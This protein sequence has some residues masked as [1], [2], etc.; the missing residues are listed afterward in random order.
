[1]LLDLDQLS[2]EA[3]YISAD[4]LHAPRL[5]LPP[6]TSTLPLTSA[7]AAAC[8]RA[9]C[10]QAAV[11]HRFS[12]V[13][14][15][16]VDF[17]MCCASSYPPTTNTRPPCNVAAVGDVL[18]WSKD[19]VARQTLFS[20]SYTLPDDAAGC[21]CADLPPGW[22]Q[23]VTTNPVQKLNRHLSNHSHAFSLRSWVW[24]QQIAMV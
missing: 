9:F 22:P 18:L 17:K 6:D 20:G 16:S 3:S 24:S 7:T 10:M 15:T 5:V 13:L 8:T 23:I 11:S 1:M 4:F 12:A 2:L 19:V 21:H 14:N